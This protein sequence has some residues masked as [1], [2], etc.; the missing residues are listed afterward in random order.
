VTK[1]PGVAVRSS[2]KT[3]FSP[4][5]SRPALGPPSSPITWVPRFFPQVYSSWGVKLTTHLHLLPGL[6]M[7]RAILLHV[8]KV[9][10]GTLH[11]YVAICYIRVIITDN[12][13]SHC[14]NKEQSCHSWRMG[15]PDRSRKK[16][17]KSAYFHAGILN[18]YQ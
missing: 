17:H 15:P 13:L 10:T 6:M 7:S 12:E 2:S 11:S 8:F 14:L 18:E 9:Q 1:P 3:Y 4:K 16:K 5:M